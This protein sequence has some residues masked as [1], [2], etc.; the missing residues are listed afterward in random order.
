MYK[1]Q[2]DF[3]F[4]FMERIKRR[5]NHKSQL[6]PIAHPA[7]TDGEDPITTLSHSLKTI[8]FSC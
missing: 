8:Y 7:P 3:L 5:Y 4:G 1:D 2:Q 6:Y